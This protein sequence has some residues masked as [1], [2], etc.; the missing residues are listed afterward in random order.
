MRRLLFALVVFGVFAGGT[1][2]GDF[3]YA[4]D[5]LVARFASFA[6][7]FVVPFQIEALVYNAGEWNFRRGYCTAP[8]VYATERYLYGLIVDHCVADARDIKKLSFYALGQQAT[9]LTYHKAPNEVRIWKIENSTLWRGQLLKVAQVWWPGVKVFVVGVQRVERG[10]LERTPQ[11]RA[12]DVFVQWF[13]T[14]LVQTEPG[15]DLWGAGDLNHSASITFGFSGG[16][17]FVYNEKTKEF[18]LLALNNAIELVSTFSY[19]Y[20]VS[21]DIFEVIQQDA[22]SLLTSSQSPPPFPGRF[23]FSNCGSMPQE[24]RERWLVAYERNA[25][26]ILRSSPWRVVVSGEEFS[27][28][29]ESV[30]WDAWLHDRI[31]IAG[32]MHDVDWSEFSYIS[33]R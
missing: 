17:A 9:V 12:A 23:C 4:H 1:T 27:I 14:G 25:E 8:L 11:A 18:E 3:P 7:P 32:V 10:P 20:S 16:P 31:K 2:A 19:A 15:H 6:K 28:G 26:Y 29:P 5:A 13:T 33:N 22:A 21:K 30:V 24:K